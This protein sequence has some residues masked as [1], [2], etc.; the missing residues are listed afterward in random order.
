MS[1]SQ[2][3][4]VL[5]ALE[6]TQ[7]L[8][9]RESIVEWTGVPKA[10]GWEVR[11]AKSK[12]QTALFKTPEGQIVRSLEAARRWLEEARFWIQCD[13]CHKWRMLPLD[14]PPV[15]EEDEWSCEKN[16]LDREH[17][18]CDAP[19]LPVQPSPSPSPRSKGRGLVE[20][21]EEEDDED[22]GDDL[23]IDGVRASEDRA[24]EARL[25]R[26]GGIPAGV[27]VYWPEDRDFYTAEILDYDREAGKHQLRYYIDGQVEWLDLRC[28]MWYHEVVDER[29]SQE[30]T[31][32]INAL[33]SERWKHLPPWVPPK[34]YRGRCRRCEACLRA[35]SDAADCAE[36]K[37]CLDKPK[38][39][40]EYK[41]KQACEQKLCQKHPLSPVQQAL[42]AEYSDVM[43]ECLI[44]ERESYQTACCARLEEEHAA[45][46]VRKQRRRQIRWA[47]K[48]KPNGL[49]VKPKPAVKRVRVARSLLESNGQPGLS[50]R[51]LVKWSSGPSTWELANKLPTELLSRDIEQARTAFNRLVEPSLLAQ[52]EAASGVVPLR[53]PE[54]AAAS[55]AQHL[56]THWQD[57][58]LPLRNG[59]LFC[60]G[61]AT[62]GKTLS[63]HDAGEQRK[64][65]LLMTHSLLPAI[66]KEMAGFSEMEAFLTSWL[67]QTY[68]VV[69]ELYFAHGLRQSPST[70]TSTGFDVHQDNEEFPFIEFTIVVKLTPDSPGGPPSQMRVLGAPINFTYGPEAGS[71]AAFRA[72]VF[73]ASVAPS[74][75]ASEHLKLAF[76][77]RSSIKGERRAKRGLAA[78]G[79]L[80]D[81]GMLAQ[82]RRLVAAELSTTGVEAANAVLVAVERSKR[83]EKTS[84]PVGHQ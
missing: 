11:L 61:Y 49:A 74:A 34:K 9:K 54:A 30:L 28:E 63:A 5:E 80:D 48:S 24:T 83:L 52:G 6:T 65:T 10:A 47:R 58:R 31:K 8:C 7:M 53:V 55:C 79:I 84:R 37:F 27:D 75:E 67:H 22:D 41:L 46:E 51:F 45:R 66:R 60:Y 15:D 33:A 14:S 16:T 40:G 20:S 73:H 71:S 56:A 25:L 76:F 59:S 4:H 39:G 82:K 81:Q 42:L 68:G 62:Y 29:A 78:A 77:F 64:H 3:K 1:S 36:C 57:E 13:R 32:R 19:E 35:K 26:F 50:E 17:A 72:R 70:L 38:F 44:S 23:V 21:S 12:K 2:R 69:V 18:S 43:V